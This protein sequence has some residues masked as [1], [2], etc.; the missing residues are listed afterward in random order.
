[1]AECFPVRCFSCNKVINPLYNLYIKLINNGFTENDAMDKLL[2]K[3]G[4]C[5]N[6]FLNHIDMSEHHLK[7]GVSATREEKN[8]VLKLDKK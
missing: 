2:L 8:V 1:M 5:R 6:I 7:Y 4:C 3:R